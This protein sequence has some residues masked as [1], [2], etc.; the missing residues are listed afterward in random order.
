MSTAALTSSAG[1]RFGLGLLVCLPLIAATVAVEWQREPP[2]ASAALTA[3]RPV[4]E[5]TCTAPVTRWQVRIGEHD[6]TPLTSDRQQWR[7]VL[8]A[9]AGSVVRIQVETAHPGTPRAVRARIGALPER[10]AWSE[11]DVSLILTVPA[12]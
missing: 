12:H 2:M 4:L 1:W 3:D 6:L 5:L 11:H 7:G 9:P 10:S 8:D